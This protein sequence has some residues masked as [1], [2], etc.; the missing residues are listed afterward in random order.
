M[1]IKRLSP[2]ALTLLVVALMTACST[3]ADNSTITDV[4][5]ST[6]TQSNAENSSPTNVGIFNK[7]AQIAETVLVD[8]NNVS[9]LLFY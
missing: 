2:L 3:P 6:I 9:I 8:E 5:A 1:N 7:T 4:D